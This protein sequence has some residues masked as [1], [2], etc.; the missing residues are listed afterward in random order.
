M[1]TAVSTAEAANLAPSPK[2]SICYLG[3]RIRA[4]AAARG[5]WRSGGSAPRYGPLRASLAA[6]MPVLAGAGGAGGAP[7][8]RLR[9]ASE[10]ASLSLFGSVRRRGAVGGGWSWRK[11][12]TTY[13]GC[14][15]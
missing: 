12:C 11:L 4:V 10:S 13:C 7:T 6:A 3:V 8:L 1:T 5:R 15:R 9:L 14:R 2:R